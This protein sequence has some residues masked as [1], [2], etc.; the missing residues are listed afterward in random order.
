MCMVMEAPVRDI[1][2][3]QT[4]HVSHVPRRYP[5]WRLLVTFHLLVAVV[6]DS[7]RQSSIY[8]IHLA[9]YLGGKGVVSTVINP[10]SAE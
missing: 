9:P 3:L 10:E 7:L 8:Y 5:K 6:F 4:Q 1:L 2:S